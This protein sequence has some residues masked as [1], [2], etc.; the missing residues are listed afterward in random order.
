MALTPSIVVTQSVL[1]PS[2]LMLQDT[3]TGSDGAITQRRVYLQKADGTYLVPAGTTTSYISFPLGGNT[4]NLSVLDRDYCL[5]LIINW[6]DVNGN[7]LY[8][9]SQLCLF[10]VY[11]ESLFYQLTQMQAGNALLTTNAGYYKNKIRLRVYLDEATNA[12]TYGSDISSAQLALDKAYGI[13]Q[14]QN[15]FF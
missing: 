4:I 2:V 7:V 6:C 15:I 14:S 9:K 13:S 11:G 10:T 8:S 5:Y 3:S 1:T 12:V